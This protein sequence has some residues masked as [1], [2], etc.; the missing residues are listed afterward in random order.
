MKKR[1]DKVN[2][3]LLWVFFSLGYFFGFLL[4]PIFLYP[5]IKYNEKYLTDSMRSGMICGF[6]VSVLLIILLSI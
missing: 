4:A 5:I 1:E 6:V 3:L 2:Y